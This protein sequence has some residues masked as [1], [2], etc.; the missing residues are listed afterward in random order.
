MYE[1]VKFATE[2]GVIIFGDYYKVERAR[3]FALLLHMMPAVKESWQEL[4]KALNAF[5]IV[6]LA[7]DMRGHGE[8]IHKADG[9][10]LN[11]KN[12]SDAE[13]QAKILDV[14]AAVKWFLDHGA[15]EERLFLVGASIGANLALEYLAEDPN[16]PFAILMSP[17]LEYRAIKADKSISQIREKQSVLCV[18]AL[19]DKYAYDTCRTLKQV[20]PATETWLLDEGGHGTDMFNEEG[21]IRRVVDWFSGKLQD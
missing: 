4:A 15:V 18:A 2:D 7:I 17:G 6:C 16:A 13:H 1:R 12:F 20:A 21:L 5:G 11:F 10:T 3:G 14:R 9:A 19:D 8:S